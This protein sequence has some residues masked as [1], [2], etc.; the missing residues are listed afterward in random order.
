MEVDLSDHTYELDCVGCVLWHSMRP[1]DSGLRRFFYT[2]F[3]N[4]SDASCWRAITEMR[5]F[6][7][8]K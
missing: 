4:E 3:S 6:L 8:H 1:D 5:I 2:I 7:Y